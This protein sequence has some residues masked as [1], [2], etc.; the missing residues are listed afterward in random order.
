MKQATCITQVPA[1]LSN[2]GTTVEVGTVIQY[3]REVFE[4]GE[5]HLRL[6]NGTY[7][8]SVFFSVKRK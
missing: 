7:V 5:H 8:P 2:N 4:N 3:V 1:I 6:Q